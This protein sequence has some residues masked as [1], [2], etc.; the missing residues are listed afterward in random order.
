M[1]VRPESAER[2]YRA[3]LGLYPS[4]FRRRFGADMVQ[5]YRDR[6]R[7]VR[8][9]RARGGMAAAWIG[10]LADVIR[11]APGEHLRRNRTMAHSLAPAPSIPA[12][13]FGVAGII[14][15][16]A[17][18]AAYAIDLPSEA[19][20]YR[21]IIFTAGV[22]AVSIGVHQ[23]QSMRAPA[24]SIGVT[25]ALIAANAAF[26]IAVLLFAP[27]HIVG[28]WTGMALWLASAVFGGASAVIGAVSRVGAWAVAAG[29]LVTLTGIDRL[30]LVSE[31]HPT[32][33]NTLSQVGIV[34]MAAG[35]IVL[36]LDVALRRSD[37]RE[38]V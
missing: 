28:F 24:V 37:R 4:E 20:L 38:I 23:R 30:G 15:G 6:L 19:F 29:S 36:G 10:L 9:G 17:M 26:L 16:L 27:G 31:A 25:V 12:R 13:V 5:L 3:I 7:D 32:V 35:W 8:D 1:T 21:L 34:T 11:T 22:T 2:L 33:F 14:A 18:L